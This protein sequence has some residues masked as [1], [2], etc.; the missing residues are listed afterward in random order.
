MLG[1]LSII[2]VCCCWPVA[3]PV[4]IGGTICGSIGL[5]YPNGKGMAVAG[6]VMSLLALLGSGGVL[7][8]V[9]LGNAPAFLP[10]NQFGR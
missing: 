4:S 3:I 6:L 2:G 10:V 1:I 5:K 8:L 9:L 7:L